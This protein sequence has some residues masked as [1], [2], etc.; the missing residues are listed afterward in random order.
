MIYNLEPLNTDGGRTVK[1]DVHYC[2]MCDET[3][4]VAE[5]WAASGKIPQALDTLI[6]L[7]KQTRNVSD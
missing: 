1:M 4:S 6:M 7:E 3:I 5:S 2:A